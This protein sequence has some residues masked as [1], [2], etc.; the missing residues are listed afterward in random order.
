MIYLG[1]VH[2]LRYVV[3]QAGDKVKMS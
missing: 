1:Y 3:R 2:D